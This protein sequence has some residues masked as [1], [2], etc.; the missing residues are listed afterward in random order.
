M[1][2]FTL[3][4]V[5]L[6]YL[7]YVQIGV[8]STF[9]CVVKNNLLL[10]GSGSSSQFKPFLNRPQEPALLNFYDAI[11]LETIFKTSA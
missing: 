9:S 6:C 11:D 10:L 4:Y 3:F 7:I 8:Y 1:A 2:N 5:D